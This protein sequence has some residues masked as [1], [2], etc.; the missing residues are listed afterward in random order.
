MWWNMMI[1]VISDVHGNYPAL[2]SV[3][4]KIDNLGCERIISLGDVSGYY[5]MVNECIDEFRKREIINILGN[6]DYYV[7]GL[8]DCP[9]SYTV[10]RITEYQRKVI[11]KENLEFLSKS[12]PYL[13][14]GFIS[15][16]HGGWKDPLD[17]YVK[18]FDFK[19]CIGNIKIYCSGHSHIQSMEKKDDIVYFNPGS[20]GQP[21]DNDNRAAFA[22]IDGN[23]VK[24]YRVEYNIDEIAKKMKEAGFEKRT[25]SCLYNGTKIGG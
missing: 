19:K 14:N 21:R 17:E 15:A 13:D 4:N 5:C 1:A 16:R 6:H 2:K 12:I 7:L 23:E 11:T 22:V 18:N 20:V 24:L 3:L 9:R 10:N 8:G 25:Y